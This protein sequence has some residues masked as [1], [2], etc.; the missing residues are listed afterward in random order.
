MERIVKETMENLK[1]N[2]FQVTYFDTAAE[3]ADYL[4]SSLSGK[5]IG[6]GG[7]MTVAALNV[8]DRLREQNTVYWHHCQPA[9]EARA[10]ARNAQVYITSANGIA[11]T[12]EIVNIDGH[13]NRV[14]EMFCWHEKVLIVSGINKIQE[15]LEKALWRA[16]NVAAPLNARRL[17]RKTPCALSEPMQCHDCHS[18]QRICRGIAI[19]AQPCTGNDGTEVVLIGESLGF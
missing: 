16:R 13:G 10:N 8:Y 18:P 7:S 6:I 5:T 14:A 17:N 3:A 1:K 19:L 11:Q 12:G 9:E 2:G 15:N 4:V